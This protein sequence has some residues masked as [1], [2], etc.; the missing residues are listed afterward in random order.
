MK[1]NDENFPANNAAENLIYKEI[2]I[3]KMSNPN[4]DNETYIA[5][6]GSMSHMVNLE[7]NMIKLKDAETQFTVE[8][9]RT[10]T[11]KNVAIST[12]IRDVKEKSIA[13]NHLVWT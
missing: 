2:F 11:R 10:L 7:E 4:H 6:S 8:H 9:S 3:A 5:D 12:S 13:L 1:K